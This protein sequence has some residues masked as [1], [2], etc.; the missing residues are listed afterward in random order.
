MKRA[1]LFLS[2]LL[3]GLVVL[4]VLPARTPIRLF[5]VL[6]GSMRPAIYEGSL[7]VVQRDNKN[8]T[9]GEVV[10]FIHPEN[11]RENVTHRIVEINKNLLTTKGDANGTA[12]LWTVG[13]E[14]VWG[15]VLFSV[16]FLGWIISFARTRAGVILLIALP[17]VLVAIDEW[18]IIF[19][20]IK[21]LKS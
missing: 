20:E 4:A 7:A 2:L 13:R 15:K 5:V 19:K 17:L 3:A 8:L 21:K 11:P 1:I 6:S 16:P 9:A 18:R 10:T 12:D 14:A